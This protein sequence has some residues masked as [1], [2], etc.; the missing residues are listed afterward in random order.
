MKKFIC[1]TFILA[2]MSFPGITSAEISA[3]DQETYNKLSKA[4]ES[5]EMR[6]FLE[7][8]RDMVISRDFK[9]QY[10]NLDVKISDQI[11]QRGVDKDPGFYQQVKEKGLVSD[12][13]LLSHSLEYQGLLSEQ[14]FSVQYLKKSSPLIKEVYAKDFEGIC[15]SGCTSFD[16]TDKASKFIDLENKKQKNAIQKIT[17]IPLYQS[18]PLIINI[19]EASSPIVVFKKQTNIMIYKAESQGGAVYSLITTSLPVDIDSALGKGFV[20]EVNSTGMNVKMP[21]GMEGVYS[22]NQVS[23]LASYVYLQAFGMLK[24]YA[25]NSANKDAWENRKIK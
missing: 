15:Q 2:T 1:M 16:I 6:N 10:E 19:M 14:F 5:I 18:Q 4:E 3:I 8:S 11:K 25:E 20:L 13:A 23:N 24:D 7:Y 17:I 21:E 9:T 12:E 22:V